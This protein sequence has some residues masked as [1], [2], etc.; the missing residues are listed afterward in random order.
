LA[1][2]LRQV[3]AAI[4]YFRTKNRKFCDLFFRKS[5]WYFYNIAEIARPF[6]VAC[7]LPA[8]VV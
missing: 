8:F 5:M 4:T 1:Q 3:L 7:G 6:S 2:V